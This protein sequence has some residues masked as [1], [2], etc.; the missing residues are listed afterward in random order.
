MINALEICL[1]YDIL[2]LYY[3]VALKSSD[4]NIVIHFERSIS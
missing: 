1:K 4:S 2:I 3:I